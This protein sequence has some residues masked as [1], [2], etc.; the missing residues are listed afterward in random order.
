MSIKGYFIRVAIA[1]SALKLAGVELPFEVQPPPANGNTA[2][3][4]AATN[5]PTVQP[6]FS[7]SLAP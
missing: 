5:H 2:S 6:A 3:G 4:G 1:L 7:N